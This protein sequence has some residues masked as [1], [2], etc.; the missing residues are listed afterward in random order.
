MNATPTISSLSCALQSHLRQAGYGV[1]FQVE[2]W[3][4]CLVYRAKERWLGRG[5][6]SGEALDH[7]LAQM[8]P[9]HLARALLDAA[10]GAPLAFPPAIVLLSD[11]APPD[12]GVLPPEAVVVE[13]SGAPRSDVAL[14]P[15]PEAAAPVMNNGTPPTPSP[16]AAAGPALVP[17][18]L[19]VAVDAPARDTAAHAAPCAPSATTPPRGPSVAVAALDAILR[20]VEQDLPEFAL[21]SAERQRLALLAWVCRAR[22]V[23]ETQPGVWEVEAGGARVARRLAELARVFWPGFVMALQLTARPDEVPELRGRGGPP[24]RT[25]RDAAECAEQVLLAQQERDRVACLDDHGW[26]DAQSLV[27]RPGDPEAMLKDVERELAVRLGTVGDQTDERVLHLDDGELEA[28][29]QAAR[30]LRWI[31]GA[32]A[33]PLAWG[34]AIGRLRRVTHVLGTQR[35]SALRAALDARARPGAVWQAILEPVHK[36]REE[37]AALVAD[38]PANLSPPERLVAWIVRAFDAMSTPEVVALLGEQHVD[39]AMVNSAAEAQPDRRLRRRL[40]E[41][42]RRLRGQTA[43]GAAEIGASVEQPEAPATGETSSAGAHDA[44][45]AR[46]RARTEGQRTL[47]VSN[48]EDGELAD[49]LTELLGLSITWCD[50]TTRRLQAVCKRLGNGGFDLV[51]SATGFQSHSSDVVLGKA[52]HSA[53]VPYIRVN[54]GRSLACVQALAREFGLLGTAVSGDAIEASETQTTV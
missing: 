26:G 39:V 50:G 7:V 46:V 4:E 37:S 44:L 23:E 49:T 21:S 51:L 25:W 32:V 31:R 12:G 10:L 28:L 20:S 16:A 17:D 33:A 22:S 5:N 13:G 19:L 36:V 14:G 42:V 3:T 43:P 47:F 24:P 27:P 34:A 6:T 41:V 18:P 15:Q 2:G 11:S 30:K 40:R 1:T 29:L 8:L 53:R 48:R 54:R 38:L 45:V 9:S 52:A 35:G